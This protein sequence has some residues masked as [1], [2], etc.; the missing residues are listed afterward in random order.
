MWNAWRPVRLLIVL[1]LL[2]AG[3]PPLTA[4]VPTQAD[5]PLPHEFT[6]I[7]MGMEVRIRLYCST[8]DQARAAATSAFSRIA[9]LDRMMSDYRPDSELRRLGGAGTSWSVV[10]PDLFVVL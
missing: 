1:A 5:S 10:S 9:E 2:G 4:R 6:Q 8:E 3:T 7:H